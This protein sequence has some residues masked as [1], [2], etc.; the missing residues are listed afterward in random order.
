MFKDL[1]E[2]QTHYDPIAEEKA[3]HKNYISSVLEKFDKL[4]IEEYGKWKIGRSEA[5]KFL[6][7]SLSNLI[8]ELICDVKNNDWNTRNHK[9]MFN[10]ILS[11][12]KNK[13]KH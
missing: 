1:P 6:L 8:E 11:L 2:G 4:N 9:E 10:Q 13:L 12:L 5:R 7:Q 3:R